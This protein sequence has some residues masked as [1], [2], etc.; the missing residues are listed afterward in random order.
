MVFGRE[1]RMPTPEEAAPGRD[2]RMPVPE[3][4]FVNGA[5]LAGP[6]AGMER[7]IFAM[8]C[9]WGAEIW[10]SRSEL[11]NGFTGGDELLH[12]G[13][14]SQGRR[15]LQVRCSLSEAQGV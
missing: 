6:F 12:A 5:P 8:G 4:H 1:P 9:F 14:L 3:A 10:L 15:R 7:G 11:E 2:E 13:N